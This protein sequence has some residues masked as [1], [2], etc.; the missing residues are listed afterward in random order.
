LHSIAR[1][2]C[3]FELHGTLRLLLHHDGSRGDLIAVADVANPQL[4]AVWRVARALLAHERAW[5]TPI[6]APLRR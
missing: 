1:G 6:S 5:V 3:D 2:R 4:A